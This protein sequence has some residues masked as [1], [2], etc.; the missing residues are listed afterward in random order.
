M[1]LILRKEQLGFRKGKR[2]ADGMFT[3]RQLVEKKLEGNIKHRWAFFDR[4]E[5]KVC[6]IRAAL[7]E[8]A[9]MIWSSTKDG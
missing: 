1:E 8:E 7:R 5:T 9:E 2:I 6:G 3:A 4:S